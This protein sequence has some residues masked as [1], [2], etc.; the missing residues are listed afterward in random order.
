MYNNVW[1]RVAHE[2]KQ[3]THARTHMY[4]R[5]QMYMTPTISDFRAALHHISE[6]VSRDE[7]IG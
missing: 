5:T 3:N 1:G 6:F 2:Q 4:A 7:R